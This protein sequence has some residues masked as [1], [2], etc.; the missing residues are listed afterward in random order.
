MLY[1][2]LAGAFPFVPAGAGEAGLPA[3]LKLMTSTIITFP[4]CEWAHVSTDAQAL[5]RWMLQSEPANRPTAAEACDHAWM[6]G[7]AAQAARAASG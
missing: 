5:V 4:A 7:P 2:L 3:L 1:L 6:R